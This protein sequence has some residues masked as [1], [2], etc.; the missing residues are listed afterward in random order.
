[1][2]T[3]IKSFGKAIQRTYNILAVPDIDRNASGEKKEFAS[4]RD[5]KKQTTLNKQELFDL[6]NTGESFG[7]YYYDIIKKEKN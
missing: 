2:V 1:M 3:S 6:I 4:I 7:G 5:C